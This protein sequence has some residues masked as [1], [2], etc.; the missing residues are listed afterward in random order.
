MEMIDKAYPQFSVVTSYCGLCS[1]RNI[2]INFACGEGE[3]CFQ[4]AQESNF[5]ASS[6]NTSVAHCSFAAQKG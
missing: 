3:K 4:D 6:V 1:L 5:T 2:K